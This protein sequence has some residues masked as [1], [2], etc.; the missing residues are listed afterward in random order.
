MATTTVQVVGRP[1]VNELGNR[2]MKVE[3]LVDFSVAGTQTTSTDVIQVLPIPKGAFVFSVGSYVHTVS[4]G[5]G[6][7][8]SVGD[9]ADVDGWIATDLVCDL[10]ADTNHS[11]PGDAYPALGGKLYTSADTIDFVMKTAVNTDGKVGAWALYCIVESVA[12]A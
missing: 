9:G 10:A 8:D 11:L 4:T 6:D 5:T 7:V 12:L 1:T 2:L 3:N